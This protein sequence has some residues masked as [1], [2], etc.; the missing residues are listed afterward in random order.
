MTLVVSG[1]PH[2]L[3]RDRTLRVSCTLRAPSKGY[4]DAERRQELLA[5]REWLP[6]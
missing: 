2:E 5:I 6:K 1:E 3:R 4:T